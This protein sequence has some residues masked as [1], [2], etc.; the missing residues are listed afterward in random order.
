MILPIV[1][2]EEGHEITGIAG[3]KELTVISIEK[4]GMNKELGFGRRVLSV[5]EKLAASARAHALRN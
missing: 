3:K 4:N 1:E 2:E 5:L